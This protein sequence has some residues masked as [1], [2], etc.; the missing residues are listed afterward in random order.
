MVD[1]DVVGI[2]MNNENNMLTRGQLQT[3]ALLPKFT[4]FLSLMAQVWIVAEVCYAKKKRHSVYHRLLAGLSFSS[5]FRSI[6][7]FLST[8]PIPREYEGVFGNVG[9]ETTCQLQGFL[10]QL[11]L[12]APLYMTAIST[13]YWLTIRCGWTEYKMRTKEL[14]YHIIPW[15]ISILFA[16]A[17]WSLDLYHP[18]TFFCW[19]APSGNTLNQSDLYRL[20][21]YYGPLWL[22]FGMI[23][24]FLGSLY[25]AIRAEEIRTL[26]YRQP[27]LFCN[28]DFD[29]DDAE[30]DDTDGQEQHSSERTLGGGNRLSYVFFRR[31]QLE[32]AWRDHPEARSMSLQVASQVVWYVFAFLLA[33]FAGALFRLVEYFNLEPFGLMVLVVTFD[34]LQGLF[35]FCV[36]RRPIYI[37]IRKQHGA[38]NSVQKILQWPGIE[39]TKGR[40]PPSG[41]GRHQNGYAQNNMPPVFDPLGALDEE[42]EEGRSSSLQ[43]SELAKIQ[44]EQ[45]QTKLAKVTDPPRIRISDTQS[46]G[47]TTTTTTTS[48]DHNGGILIPTPPRSPRNQNSG[49]LPKIMEDIEAIFSED[50]Y[51]ATENDYSDSHLRERRELAKVIDRE[52]QLELLADLNI[53]EEVQEWV[54]IDVKR[55]IKRQMSMPVTLPTN[56]RGGQFWNSNLAM[57]DINGGEISSCQDNSD[58]R[59]ENENFCPPS[60]LPRHHQTM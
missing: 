33:H 16:V 2:H 28:S 5:M 55:E 20:C 50:F 14:Y 21:F 57:P 31:S 36:Y 45:M 27:Q 40:E 41:S 42:S 43:G 59:P 8:W 13:Y 44:W 47:N 3:V 56:A 34:P 49:T 25:F 9:T 22:C 12:V 37:R 26:K 29:D 15:G 32:Q 35:D 54:S 53:I 51:N 60:S 19:I 7:F 24:Y 1:D 10:I 18:A 6:A 23:L 38:C 58:V 39:G 4:S 11:G 30:D 46:Q 17:G 48:V 52:R